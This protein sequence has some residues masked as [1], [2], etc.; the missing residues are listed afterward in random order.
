MI[1]TNKSSWTLCIAVKYDAENVDG[2]TIFGHKFS[3]HDQ[4][5]KTIIY[6][7]DEA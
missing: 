1:D 5:I 7:S 6:Y 4:G 2:C 3:N